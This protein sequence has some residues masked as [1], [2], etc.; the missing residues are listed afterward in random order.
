MPGRKLPGHYGDA[1]MSIKNVKVVDVLAE[2]N[3][4]LVKGPVPGS[5]NSLVKL[6]KV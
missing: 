6:M 4:V 2:E 1:M 5:T 3:V